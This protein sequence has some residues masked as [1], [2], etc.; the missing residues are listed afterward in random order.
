M[1]QL[2]IA[3]F[4]LMLVT[5][6]GQ[7]QIEKL[8]NGVIVNLQNTDESKAKQI[9]L[10]VITD[11]IIRVTASSTDSFSTRQS[12]MLENKTLPEVKW[13]S[14]QVADTFFLSTSELIA[15]VNV[16][17][18]EVVFTNPNGSPILTENKGGGKTIKAV[19]IED[20]DKFSIHQV[21]ESPADESFYGLG[22]HQDCVMDYKGQDVD[23]YQYNSKVAIPFI[24]SS[25]NYGILWDN[26]SHSKF[27]DIRDYENLNILRL[28]NS[29]GEPG[30]L[31]ANYVSLKDPKKVYLTKLESSINFENIPLLKSIPAEFPMSEGKVIW[32]GF[33]QSDSTGL[34]KFRLYLAG[35][36]KLWMN[37][38]LKADRWRQAW[39]PSSQLFELNME[40]GKKYPIHIEWIPNGGESYLSL[41]LKTPLAPSEQQK[42]SLYSECANEIDYYFIK[43]NNADDV[44]SGYR[45]LTGKA[46]IMPQW[47]MGFWQSRQR[48]KTQDEILG[49]VKEYR[50][51]QI[52]IDNI[53]LDW[54]YWKE[55]RWGDHEFDS[56]RFP[57]PK[58][59]MDE[60]HNNLHANLM[61]SVWPK[62]Y[63]GTKN[64]NRMNEKGWLYQKNLE[65]KNRDW[66]GKGYYSTFYDPF[67]EGA[68]KLFWDMINEK[69]FC[70]GIDGW[71]MDASEPDVHSNLPIETRKELMT[72]TAMGPGTEF[73]NAFP[74]MNAK[75]IYEGQRATDPNK[76]VFILTRSSYAGQQRYAA[77]TWS[78]DIGACWYDMKAQISAGV[79]FSM[80]GV[81]YWTQDIGGFSVEKRYE[82]PNAADAAEWQEQMTRWFEFGAFCPLYRAHGEFPLR[83]IYNIATENSPAYQALVNTSKLR[84]T[85]LPYIYSLAGQTYLNDYTIMRGLV[86]DFN[87]DVNARAINDQYMFGPSIMVSPVTT[88]KARSRE[89]YLPAGC[90]WF[91][92]HTG[93]YYAG[94][95]KVNIDAPLAYIPLM[96][97]EGSIIP[98]GPEI[99]Y[100]SEK[101]ADVITLY[102]YT[103]KDASFSIY[104]DENIN[105]NYEKGSYSLIPITWNEG[106]QELTIGAR[107]GEFNGMLK[108]RT[109]RIVW[110]DKAHPQ[111]LA[112]N[113]NVASVLQYKGD[114]ISI[115]KAK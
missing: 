44:I 81:P 34:H 9:R 67:S 110:I 39:N 23:L 97:K 56:T 76:R 43:G 115:N 20:K 17:T 72:P 80:S 93:K 111:A 46:P 90:G 15:K 1:K 92:M 60:L 14:K 32:D 100:T 103:G 11:K 75:G 88:Y 77:S 35:Y 107:K 64:F 74:L 66:V 113:A 22:Q 55:D 79:N 68:R 102:V 62:F 101:K 13:D 73:F 36:V 78:G 99:Q 24:V 50:K 37:G 98:A 65:M 87:S 95:Q 29:K 42:L 59:M 104:E 94:G 61:I 83:E 63:V 6:C 41:K 10:Q 27:G 40:A 25:K 57:N 18:G 5:S 7:R 105:Y 71:W 58:A 84:Y 70:L 108:D 109:F 45:T 82:K 114:A 8:S 21:F 49:V 30:G 54:F 2:T 33:L 16:K 91:E 48:Y 106:T 38:E 31:T 47:A 85:L 53:V 69:L 112:S 51:R 26:Y 19:K 12:L 89:V 4:G 52:P 86:M 96:I 3:L 28:Y